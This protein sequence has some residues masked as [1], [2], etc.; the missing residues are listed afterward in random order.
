MSAKKQVT[1]HSALNRLAYSCFLVWV[2]SE[3][4][5]AGGYNL[6]RYALSNPRPNAV[7]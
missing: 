7:I 5:S 2:L 6:A 3:I 4:I 1:E